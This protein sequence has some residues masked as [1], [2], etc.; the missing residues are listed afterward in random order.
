MLSRAQRAV[1]DSEASAKEAAVKAERAKER[2][3]KIEN[4]EDVAGGLGKPIDLEA[5]LL[6]AGFTKRELRNMRHL[7]ALITE[8]KD[9]GIEQD[10]WDAL[11]KHMAASD[12]LL[13]VQRTAER[14][15]L[16]KHGLEWRD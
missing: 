1:T 12:H 10:F 2:L 4:G 11:R 8:L 5:A 9:R 3:A 14:D 6:N 7:N 15:V 16:R 13:R